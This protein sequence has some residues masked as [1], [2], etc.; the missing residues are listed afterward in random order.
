MIL[1]VRYFTKYLIGIDRFIDSPNL[2]IDQV[3]RT[4]PRPDTD[5]EGPA[6][7]DQRN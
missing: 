7:H 6:S 4:G 2:D 1:T 3:L 5:R